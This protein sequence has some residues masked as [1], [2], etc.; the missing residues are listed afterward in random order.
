M[1]TSWILSWRGVGQFHDTSSQAQ[2]GP[3]SQVLRAACISV[4]HQKVTRPGPAPNTLQQ[5]QHQGW[6]AG[7]LARQG[8]YGTTR[9][10]N[11]D[12]RFGSLVGK[13]ERD[14]HP[15]GQCRAGSRESFSGYSDLY[16][17]TLGGYVLRSRLTPP[18][19]LP[20]GVPQQG[21]VIHAPCGPRRGTNAKNAVPSSSML[22]SMSLSLVNCQRPS[23][24]YRFLHSAL[25]P[26]Q[27]GPEVETKADK[28]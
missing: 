1:V 12:E 13:V 22:M 21:P 26:C 23:R 7:R 2:V 10:W 18:P 6:L 4:P 19:N 25:P 15:N 28:V 27:V 9:W 14:P 16:L 11:D 24:G 20:G 17:T 5:H 3:S 8:R